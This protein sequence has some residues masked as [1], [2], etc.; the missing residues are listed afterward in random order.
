[1]QTP[2]EL[3]PAGRDRPRVYTVSEITREIKTL[4]ESR[5]FSLWVEGEVSN[6]K[7][8]SSGHWYFTLKDAES[9]LSAV[10]FRADAAGIRFQLQDGLKVLAFGQINL[11]GKRGQYQLAASRL[12]PQ[13]L[14]ALQLAF[15]QLKK[16]L[17][18]EGLFDSARKQ[19]LPIFPRHIGVVTSP[20]GAALRD[21]LQVIN[22]RFSNLH[23]VINPVRVQGEGAA[24]EIALALDEFNVL[25]NVEVIILARGGGSLE[26]LWAFNE[27]A[28]A[29]AIA[30]SRIPVISAVGHEIDW[31][32]ADFAAD[33]RAP[34]PSAAAEL[35]V[36]KKT[37]L[38]ERVRSALRRITSHAGWRL[39]HLRQRRQNAAASYVFADPRRLLRPFQQRLDDLLQQLPR[40]L[41]HRLALR[42][43]RLVGVMAHLQA[44]SPLSVLSRGYSFTRMA[45]DGTILKTTGGLKPGETVETHLARGEFTSIV[46]EIRNQVD[47]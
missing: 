19:P 23:I 30:R 36:A 12:E 2:L 3:F 38:T 8:A 11:Y 14:G 34:T 13:G 32:I 41:R 22:R 1:M 21:I 5:F 6:A 27:E 15:E 45:A 28:V 37:E 46:K 16:K 24:A 39:Q 9:A 44:V 33:L 47:R 25:G 35:V 4:L 31:T 42:R 29:R 43:Q 26:D 10:L 40:S 20:T 18:A 7:R 17:A